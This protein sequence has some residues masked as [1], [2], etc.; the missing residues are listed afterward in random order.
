MSSKSNERTKS[1]RDCCVCTKCALQVGGIA[2]GPV[3]CKPHLGDLIDL[4]P[5]SGIIIATFLCSTIFSQRLAAVV[6]SD[7]F[8]RPCPSCPA[9]P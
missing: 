8:G 9:P 3:I 2:D 5:D 1:Q 7:L 6:S 4:I